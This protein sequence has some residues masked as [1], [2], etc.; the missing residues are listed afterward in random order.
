VTVEVTEPQF[1]LEEKN[2]SNYVAIIGVIVMIVIVLALVYLYKY[3][4][5]PYQQLKQN[6]EKNEDDEVNIHLTDF[7]QESKKRPT[8]FSTIGYA[9][10]KKR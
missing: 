2:S 3:K 7:K 1:V 8:S 10:N 9:M 6:R 4:D 5:S